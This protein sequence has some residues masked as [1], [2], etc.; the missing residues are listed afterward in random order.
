MNRIY[1]ILIIGFLISGCKG[2]IEENIL[3]EIKKDFNQDLANELNKMVEFD[4]L[5]ASNAF[6][7]SDYSHLT[8]E[9]WE[10]YKDSIFRKNQK[11]AEEMLNEYGFVGYDLAGKQG[12]N[13]FWLIVQHSDHNPEFQNKVLEKMKI[14]VDNGN[15]EPSNYGLLVDRVKLNTDKA[16]VYGTQVQYNIHTGQA[17]PKTLADSLNVNKRRKS[18]GLEPIETYLNRMSE[19]HFDM[20]KE[21]YIKKGITVPKLYKIE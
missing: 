10:I 15:A 20:N 13:D 11:R 14:E 4:Q 8:Q 9:K 7:P 3:S 5:V 2:R 1:G 19:M 12:S 18:I 16:Q 17:Y 6:P 21:G